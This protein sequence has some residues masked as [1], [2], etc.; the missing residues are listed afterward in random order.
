M[1]DYINAVAQHWNDEV[2]WTTFC[3][4]GGINGDGALGGHRCVQIN[5]VYSLLIDSLLP[6]HFSATAGTQVNGMDFDEWLEAKLELPPNHIE[7]LFKEFLG[8]ALI[9][10]S[11][12][13]PYSS[14]ACTKP[15]MT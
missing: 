6:V 2:D 1:P 15:P 11:V 12:S 10:K 14:I 9:G 4:S 13:P 3:L 7:D 5:D 8:E